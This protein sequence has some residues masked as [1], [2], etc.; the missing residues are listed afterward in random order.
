MATFAAAQ[1]RNSGAECKV[2]NRC[3]IL[4]PDSLDQLEEKADVLLLATDAAERLQ[5]GSDVD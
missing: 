2:E 4:Q 3:G 5:S 1:A